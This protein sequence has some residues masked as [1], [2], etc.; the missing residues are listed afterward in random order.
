RTAPPAHLFVP[1]DDPAIAVPRRPPPRGSGGP[2][3]GRPRGLDV[4]LRLP[5]GEEAGVVRPALRGAPPHHGG[6]LQDRPPLPRRQDPHRVL[7]R[8][9]RPG[10]RRGL[11]R[12]V[13]VGV[14]RTRGGAPGLG[15]V[16]LHRARRP[17]LHLREDA[18]PGNPRPARRRPLNSGPLAYV[19]E[20]FRSAWF[21]PHL[22]V[23]R[24]PFRSVNGYH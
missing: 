21:F 4:P 1:G 12:G 16:R 5:D 2:D 23:A 19:V 18:G 24:T 10:V 15:V 13:R 17:D 22:Q 6:P 9:R 20:Y 14:P 7:V 11:R 3:A 8:D